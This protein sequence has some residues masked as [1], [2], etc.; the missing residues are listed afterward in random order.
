M[1]FLYW[2]VGV[3]QILTGIM[4]AWSIAPGWRWVWITLAV[5]WFFV[6]VGLLVAATAKLVAGKV[7]GAGR[8]STAAGRPHPPAPQKEE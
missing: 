2:S 8:G 4:L 7:G 5:L 3:M 1:K 6:G